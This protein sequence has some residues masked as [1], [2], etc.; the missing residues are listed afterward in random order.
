MKSFYLT[1]L[2]A[3]ILSIQSCKKDENNPIKLT[4]KTETTGTLSP[5]ASLIYRDADGSLVSQILCDT[6]WEKTFNVDSE[7][8]V[9]LHAK[10]TVTN[11]T[12]KISTVAD[13]DG[14]N[15]LT[16]IQESLKSN[17]PEMF[18]FKVDEKVN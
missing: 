11:G 5:D 14:E 6:K 3:T 10:G 12:V 2:A 1:C 13:K 17:K 7:F 9:F 4:L 18:N 16:F 8:I 15:I